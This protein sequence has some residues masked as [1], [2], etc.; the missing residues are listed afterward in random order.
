MLRDGLQVGKSHNQLLGQN[1]FLRF[2]GREAL[3]TPSALCVYSV[4]TLV[5]LVLKVWSLCLNA[6]LWERPSNIWVTMNMFCVSVFGVSVSSCFLWS[7]LTPY[8][9]GAS[10]F[11]YIHLRPT[12]QTKVTET[13][14][15]SK[16]C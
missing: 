4:I 2:K 11:C 16:H 1:G 7:L 8:Q 5:L 15:M 13:P 3:A 12:F 6:M 14:S 10:H 9:G